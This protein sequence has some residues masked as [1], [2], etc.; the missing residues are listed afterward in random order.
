MFRQ[1]GQH[2]VIRADI[3]KTCSCVRGTDVINRGERRH[4]PAELGF[5]IG[6]QRFL[7]GTGAIDLVAENDAGETH[8]SD[9]TG[10]SAGL[11]L[12]PFY[13]GNHQNHGIEHTQRAFDFGDEIRVTRRIDE[14][15][16]AIPMHQRSNGRADGDSTL[17][18]QRQSIG[19]GIAG[20]DASK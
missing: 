20:I 11:R 18:F 17:L 2:S 10:E 16:L 15:N 3:A 8:R 13:A 1:C 9:G 14:I 19:V 5:Q 6:Q 12:H 4:F 7:T